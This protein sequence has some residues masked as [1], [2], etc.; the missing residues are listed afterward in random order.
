MLL[1]PVSPELGSD[2]EFLHEQVHHDY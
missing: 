2:L 1:E